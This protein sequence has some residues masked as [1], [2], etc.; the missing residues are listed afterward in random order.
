MGPKGTRDPMTLAI[1]L[2][3]VSALAI[4]WAWIREHDAASGLPPLSIRR[5]RAS[6]ETLLR[7]RSWV[8]GFA[9]E[10][11]GFLCYVGALTL[12][13][14]ALVQSLSAGGLGILA[15]LSSRVAGVR[16]AR[17]ELLGVVVSVTGLVFLGI[18]L[19]GATGQGHEGVWAGILGWVAASAVLAAVA[20]R[21]GTRVLGG[22]AAHGVAAGILFAAGDVVTKAVVTGGSRLLF[23]PAMILA[24]S[25]GTIVLQLGFQRGGALTT[26]GMTT[27]FTNALPIIAGTTLYAEP[28][29][30]GELG[31]LR[32]IAFAMLIAGGALLSRPKQLA[33]PGVAELEL[34][35]AA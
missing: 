31:V 11:G 29:P 10:A 14:L 3:F 30:N 4:N 19:A 12:A 20:V 34:A 5:P 16:L 9:A 7:D 22:A 27:L 25:F 6:V 13:P 18:S 28:F 35:G 33:E 1:L 15:F 23:I 26:A 24:Y 17:R 32:G 8:T 2:T 21:Y